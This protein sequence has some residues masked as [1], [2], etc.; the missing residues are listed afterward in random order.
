MNIAT[1]SRP[2]YMPK[3]WPVPSS[4]V[5]YL[6]G[7]QDAIS[8]T[9][10][11]LSGN[12]N[13]GTLDTVTWTQL[14]NGLWTWDFAGGE[15]NIAHS[16]TL[17]ITTGNFSVVMW[18]YK[19]DQAQ[20]YLMGKYDG[21]THW[22]VRFNNLLWNF[23]LN[24]DTNS[25]VTT[26]TTP[27]CDG[28]WHFIAGTR[29]DTNI[30]SYTDGALDSTPVADTAGDISNAVTVDIGKVGVLGASTCSVGLPRMYS[31]ALSATQ[32]AGIYAQERILFGV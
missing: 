15:I 17:N 6:E 1:I 14:S 30:I 31:I 22:L 27:I 28:V 18:V 23:N 10:K 29:D 8:T 32:I 26:S 2:S 3:Y 13:N 12:G 4:C 21:T 25:P 7:Q 19:A 11:D 16:A 9:V 24:D 20:T 5:L